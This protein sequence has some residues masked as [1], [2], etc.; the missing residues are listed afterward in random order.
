MRFLIRGVR[1]VDP[2]EGLDGVY[3]V[4]IEDGIIREVSEKVLMMDDM[5]VI[6]GAGKVLMPGLFDMH[7]H[8]R[9]PGYE[10]KEDIH[11]GTLAA[12]RGGVTGL[13]AMPNTYPTVQSAEVVRDIKKRIDEK[14]VVEVKLTG[15]ITKG[16]QGL[17]MSDIQEMIIEG[18]VAVTDDGRTTMSVDFMKEA[19][20]TIKPHDMV[21][22][23]HA[24]DHDIVEGGAVHEGEVSKEL[25]IAGIP[26]A[27]EYNIV[28]RDIA[29]AKE[30]GAKL[31]IAHISTKEAV[32]AVRE[33]REQGLAVTAEAGPH[34]FMLTDETLKTAGTLAKVNPPLRSEDHRQAVEQGLIDG[35]ITCIATD[36]APHTLEE[37]N[38]DF[39]KAPFGISGVELSLAFTY[40]HFV[41]TGKLDWTS[42]V[43]KMAVNP[44]VLLNLPVP[45]VKVGEKANLAL[46]D[47]TVERTLKNENMV[48]RGKNTPFEGLQVSGDVVMTMYD[49]KVVYRG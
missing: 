36:H 25:G 18:I 32:Q 33:A 6:G 17:E 11:S 37:K 12:A 41:K 10:H 34:H 4:L 7:V 26:A 14:A 9:E 20:N 30:T 1:V 46:F 28:R 31:H 48:S 5:A 38:K 47:M 44:R 13:L 42:I 39:Y 27:A 19:F 2:T 3:S 22:I 24:E 15:S 16:L 23:S 29:L 40:S 45:C 35:T 21:L 49:G 43:D 8:L